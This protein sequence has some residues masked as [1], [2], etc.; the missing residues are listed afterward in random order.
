MKNQKIKLN[1]DSNML[2]APMLEHI[3]DIGDFDF[4]GRVVRYYSAAENSYVLVG[5]YPIADDEFLKKSDIGPENMLKLS[6]GQQR[7]KV[8]AIPT[9]QE[10]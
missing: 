7:A 1:E 8:A 2:L 4:Q 6:L 5:K 10:N 9:D 3:Q